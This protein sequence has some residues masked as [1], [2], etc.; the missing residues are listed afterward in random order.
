VLSGDPTK[1]VPYSA[2]LKF[3]AHYAIAVHSHPTDEHV[4]ITSGAVTFGMATR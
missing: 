4:V 3:P 1:A 2:R